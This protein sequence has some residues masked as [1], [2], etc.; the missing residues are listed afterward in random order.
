MSGVVVYDSYFGNTKTVAEAIAEQLRAEGWDVDPRSVR[1]SRAAAP[2]G[3][4]IF[5]G[6]PVRMGSVTGRMKRYVKYLDQGAWQDRP[7]VVFTTILALPENATPDRIRSQEDYDVAAGRKL[8]DLARA[9]GLN[10]VEEPLW[11]GVKGLKGPLVESG[12]EEA[13]RF[14]HGVLVSLGG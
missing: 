13:R 8:R 5:V 4:V 2:Q 12:V 10:A 14:T 3:D 6:S 1:D 11:V 9:G 7:I